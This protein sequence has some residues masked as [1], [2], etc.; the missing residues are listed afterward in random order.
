MRD[1]LKSLIFNK[2]SLEP[3]YSENDIIK[4][5]YLDAGIQTRISSLKV[6]GVIKKNFTHF[7]VI[8]SETW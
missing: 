3:V 6:S 7:K 8:F 2:L 1:S 4:N 5:N